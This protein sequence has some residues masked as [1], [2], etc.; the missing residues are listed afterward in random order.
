MS[1]LSLTKEK[2]KLTAEI[3]RKGGAILSEPCN[4][5][6]GIQ[7]KFK[8]RVFCVVHE[9][10]KKILEEPELTLENVS[11]NLKE[12]LL[13][14]IKEISF[15]LSKEQDIEKQEKYTSLLIQYYA[16]LKELKE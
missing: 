11:A 13:S 9:D 15:L 12:I 6:G 8:E 16:L 5:C 1:V 14:K 10:V 2:M 7:V 3:V 4:V